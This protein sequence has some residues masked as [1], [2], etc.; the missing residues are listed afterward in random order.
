MECEA[1]PSR[2]HSTEL[3]T[4]GGCRASGR[5]GMLPRS[6]EVGEEENQKAMARSHRTLYAKQRDLEVVT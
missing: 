6:E 3:H 1:V 4:F 2:N 5:F